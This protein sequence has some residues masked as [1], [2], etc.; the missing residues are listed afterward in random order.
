MKRQ[1]LFQLAGVLAALLAMDQA[2]NAASIAT[3]TDVVNEGYR[4]P[5]GGTETNAQVKDE[6]VPDEAL[7][8][9]EESAIQVKFVD[10]SELT[11]EQSSEIV[12]N[13]Y[14]YSNGASS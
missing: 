1:I 12:L 7:R 6:L 3:V 14:V 5:P 11:V 13:D 4:T 8:T 2:A 9:E 10:G